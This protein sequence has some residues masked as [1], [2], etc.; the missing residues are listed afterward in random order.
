MD[1]TINIDFISFVLGGVLVPV[2]IA[3]FYSSVQ[4]IRIT[5]NNFP[6]KSILW[7]IN[8]RVSFIRGGSTY[9]S[10]RIASNNFFFSFHSAAENNCQKDL[11]RIGTIRTFILLTVRQKPHLEQK[12]QEAKY[13]VNEESK[14]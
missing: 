1:P 12:T 4:I 2:V 6:K 5:V 14:I 10:Y 9:G 8:S 11:F 3:I 13:F 7:K